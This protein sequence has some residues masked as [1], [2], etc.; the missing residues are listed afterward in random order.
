MNY[1]LKTDWN[2]A[3]EINQEL[4]QEIDG[5]ITR[6]S[7]WCVRT[8]EDGVKRALIALG[9]TPPQ[10]CGDCGSEPSRP[11][12]GSDFES[13]LRSVC[14]QAP[15]PEAYD[16]AKSAWAESERIATDKQNASPLPAM[17]SQRRAKIKAAIDAAG[18]VK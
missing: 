15:T 16:L 2:L 1:I 4:Q 17:Q 12:Y 5:H 11:E 18:G 3:G 6:L 9:W 8:R 7:A 13:W 14:F 10:S